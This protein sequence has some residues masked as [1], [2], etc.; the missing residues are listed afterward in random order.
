MDDVRTSSAWTGWV[1]FAAIMLVIIGGIDVFEGLI[2]IIRGSYYAVAPNQVI[3][4]DTT[5]WGWITLIMGILFVLV[6]L[7]LAAKSGWAR[8]TAVVIIIVNLFNQM[9]YLGSAGFTLWSL[10]AVTLQIIVLFALTARWGEV[11]AY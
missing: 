4:F 7:A 5:T 8:W 9:G 3:V 11:S 6:G 10:T 2:G 1:G